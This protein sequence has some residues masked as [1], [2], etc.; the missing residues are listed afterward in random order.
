M[1]LSIQII[2]YNEQLCCIQGPIKGSKTIYKSLSRSILLWYTTCR[3]GI[4]LSTPLLLLLL[5]S[6][7]S[8]ASFMIGTQPLNVAVWK[9]QIY[10]AA[11]LSKLMGELT[12]SV[13]F[14][15][16]Q[17]RTSGTTSWLI[18]SFVFTSRHQIH[19]HIYIIRVHLHILHVH[20]YILH[21]HLYNLHVH[22]YIFMY[23]YLFFIDTYTFYTLVV[24][25]RS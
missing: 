22:L 25:Y 3:V 17:A 5:T 21:V 15:A 13:L 8:I 2:V 9:R 10:A 19:V 12:H 20:L 16:R 14:S 7:E 11:T 18:R 1:Y 4:Y 23:T 24:L 6:L